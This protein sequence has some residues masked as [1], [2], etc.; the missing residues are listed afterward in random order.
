MNLICSCGPPTDILRRE[1]GLGK[2][3]DLLS[4]SLDLPMKEEDERTLLRFLAA[5]VLTAVTGA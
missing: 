4:V 2:I 1:V 3:R 5:E